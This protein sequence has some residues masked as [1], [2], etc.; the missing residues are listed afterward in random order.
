MNDIQDEL[1]FVDWTF[2]DA[3]N[4]ASLDFD[5]NLSGM[6]IR[7]SP[8]G[9]V[10]HAY[11]TIEGSYAF[12]YFDVKATI[13]SQHFVETAKCSFEVSTDGGEHWIHHSVVRLFEDDGNPEMGTLLFISSFCFVFRLFLFVFFFVVCVAFVFVLF[14]ISIFRKCMLICGYSLL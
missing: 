5:S 12:D 13:M 4:A 6:R 8:D 14:D 9:G 1:D 3:S 2:V 7:N 11:V 10:S